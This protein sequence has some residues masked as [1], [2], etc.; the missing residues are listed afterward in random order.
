M[1]R[2]NSRNVADYLFNLWSN[3]Q[4]ADIFF[5][6]NIMYC[7]LFLFCWPKIPVEINEFMESFP[8]VKKMEIPVTVFVVFRV[9]YFSLFFLLYYIVSLLYNLC[10]Q[11]TLSTFS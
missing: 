11:N 2:P 5:S 10:I 4:C 8:C 3:F 6:V 1:K 7:I 9:S